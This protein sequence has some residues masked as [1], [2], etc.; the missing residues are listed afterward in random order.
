MSSC[1]GVG[2]GGLL[3]Y[4]STTVFAKVMIHNFRRLKPGDLANTVVGTPLYLSPE[5]INET[6][7]DTKVHCKDI[8]SS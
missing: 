7:Y 2:I 6:P 4:N 5:I 8:S 3:V 1:S